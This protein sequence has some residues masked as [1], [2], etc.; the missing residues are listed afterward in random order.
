[1]GSP[2]LASAV[3]ADAGALRDLRHLRRL[4]RNHDRLLVLAG[5]GGLLRV[6]LGRLLRLQLRLTRL[7]AALLGHGGGGLLR[8]LDGVGQKLGELGEQ[9]VVRRKERGNLL[10][11]VLDRVLLLV[12]DVQDLEKR[13]VDLRLVDEAHLQFFDTS[14]QL[15]CN[16]GE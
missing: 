5:D 12:V 3:A 9:V 14:L 7:L 11:D 1:M 4:L 15:S 2:P 13:L 16:I 10:V 8:L 6:E